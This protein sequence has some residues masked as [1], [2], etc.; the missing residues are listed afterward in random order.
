MNLKVKVFLMFFITF[1]TMYVMAYMVTL[2]TVRKLNAAREEEF[3]AGTSREEIIRKVDFD[4]LPPEIKKRF[5]AQASP[6]D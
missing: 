5:V 1:L 6:A 2:K 3:E 4:K